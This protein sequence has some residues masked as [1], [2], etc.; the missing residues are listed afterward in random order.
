VATRTGSQ[1]AVTVTATDAS[2]SVS[3][4]QVD[5]GQR[6]GV[7]ASAR[8]QFAGRVQPVAVGGDGHADRGQPERNAAHVVGGA[9]PAGERPSQVEDGRPVAVL[10]GD[11]REP[12]IGGES[13][14]SIAP[15]PPRGS[16]SVPSTAP[17]VPRSA[18]AVLITTAPLPDAASR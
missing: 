5:H 11:E 16:A 17:A 15:M 8:G 7:S 14:T 13:A 12:V 10:L 4:P 18:R 3:A 1:P 2:G 6:A 9:E